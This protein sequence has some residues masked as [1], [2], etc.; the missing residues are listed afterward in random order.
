M[1]PGKR[2]RELLASPGLTLMPG[3]Y[4]ALSA[5]LIEAAGFDA[6]VAGGFAATA[7]L[8]GAPDIG[9]MT[10]HDYADQYGRIAAAVEIPVY[11]DGDTGFGGVHNVQRVVRAFERA[12]IAGF[13]IED[14]VYPKRCGYL[15]GKDV[16]PAEQMIAK[17]KAAV[18]ARRDPDFLIVART[19]AKAVL[20]FEA[21]LERAQLYVAAGADVARV[22]GADSLDEIRRCARDVPGPQ[23]ANLSQASG[24]DGP[25]LA[26]LEAAGCTSVSFP[27]LALF[28]AAQAV[29]RVL[30]TVHRERSLASVGA[31]LMSLGR[32]N[33]L[34]G[35]DL[36]NGR[37]ERFDREAAA[38]VAARSATSV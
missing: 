11:C 37:E 26:D 5:R 4:D 16:I 3:A 38:L 9:M 33:E 13:F 21:A 20:G 6:L 31:S 18:D 22:Q 35:L 15:P 32:Y 34:V 17:I 19:D 30:A 23:M 8:V 1:S 24:K 2:L 28:A 7:S 12:G 25:S 29:E 36:A 14:Q 27:S 10:M